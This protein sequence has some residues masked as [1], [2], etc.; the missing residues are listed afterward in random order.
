MF[1]GLVVFMPVGVTYLSAILLLLTLVVA[2]GGRE[3][4]ARLRANP[5]WWP[6]M[7]YLA[8]T[9]LV[10]AFGRHY[11]ETPSN[12][13]HGIRIGLTI[14]MAMALTREEA[15]WALRGFLLAAALGVLLVVAYYAI[16]FPLWSPLRAVVMEVGNKSISN[17][18]L[19]SVVASTAAV[20]GIAQIA[21]HR[22][23]RAIP[24]F[25]LML[26]L[27]LVVALPLTSRTSVLA[28]LLVV[29]VVCIHQWRSH[30][31][32]LV[33]ALV[34]GTVVLGAGLYQLPQLQHKVE[35][36]VQEIEDAQNGAVFHGSW[37]I[38]YYMYRDTGR[39]IAD[40]PLTGW[41]IGGWT[42]QW[43]K[44]GPALF[45]DSNMPH[46]DFLWVGS[47][48]GLPALLSLLLIMVTAVWQ[49]WKRPDIAGRYALAATLIA[50]IASS[51]NS[52][53]RDAQ[54]G[55]ALLWIAMIY[56][57]LA[58]EKNDPNPW[59]GLLPSRRVESLT[60]PG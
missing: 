24:A 26:G 33:G 31:K 10:L 22:P 14:L 56:L 59:R 48:G 17:A 34:L 55:L 9:L 45:A 11:P 54:I 8:W 30:L 47:Q 13:F 28:L 27:G 20:W 16:G 52:A 40:R 42:E 23:L 53:L 38:R 57:R 39:M 7:A 15:L 58:Q 46:N 51:V 43:H 2:G 21:A 35:T 49:A 50:L 36:G 6:V 29:P 1:W 4:L 60:Q 37:I 19:F 5:L 18:L 44:R 41:G 25:V 3:R 12:L 32:M